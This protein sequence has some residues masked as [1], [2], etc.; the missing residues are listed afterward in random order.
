MED[1]HYTLSRHNGKGGRVFSREAR[2]S[3]AQWKPT[4]NPGPSNYQIPT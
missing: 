1:G 4:E 2:F 3:G